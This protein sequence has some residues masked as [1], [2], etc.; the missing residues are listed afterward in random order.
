MTKINKDTIVEYYAMRN[1]GVKNQDIATALG[2]Y[3]YPALYRAVGNYEK[4]KNN[5]SLFE[6]SKEKK[7]ILKTIPT[8]IKGIKPNTV[9]R[10]PADVQLKLEIEELIEQFAKEVLGTVDLAEVSD[11]RKLEFLASVYK[12]K[13]E[14]IKSIISKG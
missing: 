11:E 4:K 1:K 5:L 7:T 10:L 2:F 9:K 8:P 12:N 14:L 13:N 3:D 6:N